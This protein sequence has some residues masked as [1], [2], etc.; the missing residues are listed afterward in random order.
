MGTNGG[1]W[2]VFHFGGACKFLFIQ[3]L[4]LLIIFMIIFGAE[5]IPS[6]VNESPFKLIPLFLW[7]DPFEHFLVFWYK[8]WA[9]KRIE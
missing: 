4:Q 3:C 6:L 5:V 1:K 9:L 8:L 2:G 7:Y